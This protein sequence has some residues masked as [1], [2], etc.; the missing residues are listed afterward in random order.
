MTFESLGKSTCTSLKIRRTND[1]FSNRAYHSGRK[2]KET[3]AFTFIRHRCLHFRLEIDGS[4]FA[5]A[6]LSSLVM[7]CGGFRPPPNVL[8]GRLTGVTRLLAFIIIC[9]CII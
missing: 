2:C 4:F 7:S 8:T 9:V 6:E 1:T 5:V 3:F